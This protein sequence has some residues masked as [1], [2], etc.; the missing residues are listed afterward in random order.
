MDPFTVGFLVVGAFFFIVALIKDKTKTKDA[1]G[2]SKKMMG[3]MVI[4]IAGIVFLIG[5]VLTIIPPDMIKTYLGEGN[6]VVSSIIGALVGSVTLIPGFVAFPLV[7][8]LVA[9]GASIVPT[10]AF[11]TT[12][13]MVGV[14]TYPLEAKEFGR[15]FALMRNGLSFLG[16]IVIA[17]I[18]GVVL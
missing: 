1:I 5:L 2:K 3:K 15:K 17:L 10:V 7:G 8:S 12:L 16:A 14:V 4:D 6:V 13:T 18:M 9:S 11:L